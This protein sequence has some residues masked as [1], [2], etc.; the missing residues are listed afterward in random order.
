MAHVTTPGGSVV[1]SS[2]Q[3][4]RQ[5]EWLRDR[6]FLTRDKRGRVIVAAG[7]EGLSFH[8][9]AKPQP[10]A[11]VPVSEEPVLPPP[12][13]KKVAK[14]AASPKPKRAAAASPESE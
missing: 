10:F 11:W 8:G 4:H 1:A 2:A 12:A 14:P 7:M 13:P 3:P 5:R 9:G 6:C